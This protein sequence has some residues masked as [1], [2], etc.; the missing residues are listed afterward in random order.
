MGQRDFVL[1]PLRESLLDLDGSRP[2]VTEPAPT[3]LASTVMLVRDDEGPLE[4]FMLRR[5]SSMAFAPSM[6]VFPGG[7]VDVELRLEEDTRHARADGDGRF[8]FE[9]VPRGLAQ[10]VLRAPG[11]AQRPAPGARDPPSRGPGPRRTTAITA[12]RLRS[13]RLRSRRLPRGG[14]SEPAT[15]PVGRSGTVARTRTR[16]AA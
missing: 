10:F 8:V 9:D 12:R 11:D 16:A 5:V 15:C 7:G 14:P 2:E 3:K 6:H 1:G 13:R 4:V